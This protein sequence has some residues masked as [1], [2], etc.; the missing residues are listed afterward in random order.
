MNTHRG[1]IAKL[2][3]YA[4]KMLTVCITTYSNKQPE[5]QKVSSLLFTA[6]FDHVVVR[7]ICLDSMI[8]CIG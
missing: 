1:K 3:Y 4:A 5:R 2:R 8:T 6:R 7:I